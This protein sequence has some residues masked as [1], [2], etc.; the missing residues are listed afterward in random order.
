MR[1][2]EPLSL[3]AL[4]GLIVFAFWEGR[5]LLP[6]ALSSPSATATSVPK[7]SESK[8]S[9]AAAQRSSGSQKAAR[10]SSSAP[11]NRVSAEV[12]ESDQI[13]TGQTTVVVPA[14]E[15]PGQGSF[16]PGTTRSQIRE[17]FGEPTLKVVKREGPLAERYFYQTDQTHYVVVTLTDG[18][19]T[20]AQTIAR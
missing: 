10:R 3:A 15:T 1:V 8:T 5:S 11:S 13:P 18:H 7:T 6:S 12:S 14:T 17:Q 19:V 4:V 9:A 16:T 2:V 20:S